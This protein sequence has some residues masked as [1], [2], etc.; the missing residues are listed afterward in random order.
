LDGRGR[1]LEAKEQLS[2]REAIAALLVGSGGAL[3]AAVV[4]NI[5]GNPPSNLFIKKFPKL[6]LGSLGILPNGLVSENI[7]RLP[8]ATSDLAPLILTGDASSNH[9]LGYWVV[10]ETD[11]NFEV[12]LGGDGNGGP[13]LQ[14]A[15]GGITARLMALFTP[16]SQASS[17]CDVLQYFLGP[18]ERIAIGT[19]P[20]AGS[21]VQTWFTTDPLAGIAGPGGFNV[22]VSQDAGLLTPG[23]QVGLPTGING[24]VPAGMSLGNHRHAF[25][26]RFVFSGV[27]FNALLPGGAFPDN[28]AR[29]KINNNWTLRRIWAF[30][31]TGPTGGTETYGIVNA[32]GALQGTAVTIPA[33]AGAVSQAESAL[34]T[35]N[36]TGGTLYYLAQTASTAIVASTN[37]EVGLEYTMNV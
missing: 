29:L 12:K 15:T 1:R 27:E 37:V 13:Q 32:G 30:T 7:I 3:A 2:R 4:T 26:G 35:T 17:S 36:L 34:Q 18:P 28:F 16:P 20:S 23:A 11:P 33:S 6:R 19:G 25:S 10:S 5:G 22:D 24:A 31:K 8:S 14:M 9:A 21:G